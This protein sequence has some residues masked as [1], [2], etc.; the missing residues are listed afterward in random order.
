[1]EMGEMDGAEAPN[2]VETSFMNISAEDSENIHQLEETLSQYTGDSVSVNGL[3]GVRL[4]PGSTRSNLN[5][6]AD[7]L[8][9]QPSTLI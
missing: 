5:S 2:D 8:L 3:K 4:K 6:K 9:L 7:W 1:M